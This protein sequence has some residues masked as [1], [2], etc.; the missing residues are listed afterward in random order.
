MKRLLAGAVIAVL[1]ALPGVSRAETPSAAR[2]IA[3]PAPPYLLARPAP[4]ADGDAIDYAV[5]EKASPQLAEFAGGADGVYITS[6]AIA[7]V[8]AVVLLV[9]LL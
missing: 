9:V 6:G 7:L 2:N 3:A 8:L 5:R 4:A 1:C